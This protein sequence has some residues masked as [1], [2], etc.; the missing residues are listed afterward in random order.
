MLPC[1][2]YSKT[3]VFFLYTNTVSRSILG[4]LNLRPT[5]YISLFIN[6]TLVAILFEHTLYPERWIL[7][8]QDMKDQITIQT[9]KMDLWPSKQF[10]RGLPH[11]IESLV[12]IVHL[13]FGI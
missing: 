4:T 6:T 12:K 7:I 8:S 3:G 13:H 5:T 11:L 2:I 1:F 10:N 9:G